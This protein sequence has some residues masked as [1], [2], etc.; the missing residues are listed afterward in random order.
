MNIGK[1][2]KMATTSNNSVADM[3]T[4]SEI[5]EDGINYNL[6][7][8]YS[9]DI[10]YTYSGTILIA[11]NPYKCINIFNKDYVQQYHMA[12]MGSLDP[13]VFAL[14]E[15]AYRSIVEEKINQSCLISGES[16]AGKTESTKFVLQYLCAITSNVS[17]WIQQQILEANT[18][19]EAFGNAKTIRNDN[20]SRFGKFM[21]VCFNEKHTIE[22]CVIQDYLLEQSRI[23]FQGPG[24][25]NYHVMYQLVAQGQTNKEMREN[26]CLRPPEFYRYLN[27]IEDISVDINLES[28]KFNELTMALTVLQIP[29]S[30]IDCIFKVLSSILWLG[31]IEFMDID[32]ERCEFSKTDEEIIVILSKMM[33]LSTNE[34]QMVLL[35]RQINVRGNITE[36]P[37]KLHEARE[38]R[39]AMARALYSKTFTWLVNKINI[40]TSPGKDFNQFLG[41]L[42][43][44]GFENFTRNSFEQLCINYTNEKLHKFFNHYV[45]ALEL[46]IYKQEDINYTHV[47]FTDNSL[48]LELIEKPPRCIFKLLTEQCHMPKGSDSAYLNNLHAEF[49]YNPMYIKGLDRRHWE[50]EFGIRHYAGKVIYSVEG[51][52][53]KN[54]DMQ[55]DVLFDY[56]S[57]SE[58]TFLCDLAKSQDQSC[59]NLIPNVSTNQRG[60][61]KSKST[62]SDQF[63]QQLQSL[64]DVLQNTKLWYIRCIKPNSLKQANIYNESLV[65]DQLRYLGI[66]DIIRIRREGFPIHL[67]FS[68]FISK[69]K[70]VIRNKTFSNS[71]NDILLVLKELKVPETEWQIGK[72]K[73]FLRSSAIEP[74]EDERKRIR[75]ANSIIIQKNWRRYLNNKYYMHVKKSILIIQHAYR[76]WKLR[77]KFLRIRRSVIIIQSRL[78]GV[79]AREVATALRE[80]RRVDEEMK[81]RERITFETPTNDYKAIEDCER[82]VQTEM[83]VLTNMA[84]HMNNSIGKSIDKNTVSEN[85]STE[86]GSAQNIDTV[87]LDNLFAFLTDGTTVPTNSVIEEIND[88]M[89]SLVQDL[90][91]EIETCMQKEPLNYL[92]DQKKNILPTS[93]LPE[94]LMAPPPPP[95][96]SIET[97]S[98]NLKPEPIYE[99]L[100]HS[101]ESKHTSDINIALPL[102]TREKENGIKLTVSPTLVE[103]EREQRRKFRVEKKLL[104]M[105][106]NEIQ[107]EVYNNDS[108]YNILNF[109]E[110]FFN[111]HERFVDGTLISTI[112]R[113]GKKAMDLVPKHEMITFTRSE[114]IATSHIHMYDPENISLSCN[115]FRELSKYMRG[116]Q[117]AERELQ[118]IQYIIGLGIEREELRDEIFVQC[119][120]QTTN[121]P[122]LEWTDRLWLLMCLTI[123]AFQPSK[124]LFRYYFSFLKEKLEV[125]D[126]KLRQYA[127]W[128]F[129]NCKCTKVSTRLQPPS[130]VEVAAMRRLGTIVC[131]F[132]FLDSRTKAIDVHPTDTAIDAVQ[133][134]ADKLNLA[135]I[136]GWAIFQ[137]RPDGEE[138]IKSFEYLYDIISE[139]ESKQNSPNSYKRLSNASTYGENRFVFK[140]R[141]FKPTRELSQD[142]VE[143]GMLY[144]QAVYSIVKCDEFPVSEKVAL[145]LA[146]LQAQVALGDPS[147]QPKPEY[148]CDINSFLPNRIS[149]TREQQFWIP[150]LAQAHRQYGSSR[151]E[152]T[153]KVLYLSCVMQYPLYGTTMFNVIYKG[154]WSFVNNIILGINCEGVLFIQPEDKV[155]IYQFKY[156][157]IESILIDPS[158]SFLTISL[159]RTTNQ[160]PRLTKDDSIFLD[161]Q[162]CFVFETVQKHEIGALIISYYPSLS[163]WI[164]SNFDC[165]KKGKG[166]T[167]EDRTRLYQ[168]VIICRRQLIDLNIVRKPHESGGFLRNTLRRLSKH[169]IE[170]LRAEQRTSPQDHGETYKGF[171]HS[172]WAFSK[173]Q[174]TFCLS[175]LTDQDETTMVQ[176]F[177]SILQFSGLGISGDT[178]KRAEDEHTRIVQ[179]IMDKCM[180]KDSLLNELYLQLI[181]QTTDHP[182]ANSRVNLR[183]W[184]LLSVACSVILPSTKVIRKYLMAHLK[185]CS[186]DFI[187]EEGKYAR[188]AE[189]CFL[190]TQG[191]RRRQWTPSCEEILCTTNR[192]PCYS[193]VFFMDGQY[194]SFEF[195]PSSTAGDVIQ[196]IKKTIGL[197]ENS[198]G[199]ALYEMLGNTER[200]LSNEEKVCD[201]MAKWERYRSVSK[202]DYHP[203][204]NSSMQPQ[205]HQAFLFKKHLF[206][207]A[208]INLD[209]AIEKELLYHQILHSLRSERYPITEMEAIMLTALQ[210]QLELGDYSDNVND[211]GSVASHCLPPRFVPNIPHGAVAMHHQS[212]KG[213]LPVEAKK[214][215]LNLIQ[216]WPLHRATIFD[217]M[218]SFTSNWPRMLW[219]AVDQNGIHLLEHRSRN[220]LCS[221]EY[222]SLIS[223]SPNMNS[224]M[225][226]TGTEK[227]QSKVI[228]STSQA[229]QIAT[230]INEYSE[231]VKRR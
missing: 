213:M 131:R 150:I 223:F 194:Y 192:R 141:L 76:G 110:H 98:R 58:H 77:I 189:K 99:A 174:L 166:I 214:A 188:F 113:K 191:T 227:K 118:S 181:K 144:A 146:G 149:K 4:I 198:L 3:T 210:A 14:A 89:S 201:V 107:N 216:S 1:K 127:Q 13:H 63:R 74:L 176:I 168:N 47:E 137:S 199:Y 75:C 222:E 42:D 171:S 155:I 226:F 50:T 87:D 211:Y 52:V 203:S 202:K 48:C 35:L 21:Q 45:F 68:E 221:H 11:V 122:N 158:D 129:D 34:L 172:F 163:N 80:M 29:Q 228:L 197:Q 83:K 62:V 105:H 138:H 212:L 160:S 200:S 85:N 115:I 6:R 7:L 106:Q 103:N 116:E 24:E 217:V 49:E 104:E 173:Q 130:S 215:F 193:K 55:Q 53:D 139:W 195:H 112:T 134:L 95:I 175:S 185:R 119:M 230:L 167:N 73:I 170:K 10:I 135:S 183:N 23:T 128:C 91:G 140:K 33:G 218:Q 27:T 157:D 180:R 102:S 156:T 111:A 5:D 22:G 32:G 20:S 162:K 51:F 117:N 109:A 120:R 46:S 164:L 8:R 94:P 229:F 147:N 69:Y 114:K 31:N 56:M 161:L 9:N 142:P 100:T 28:R 78:R 41:V 43:I 82:L 182:D 84:E 177:D 71:L 15:A 12:K 225:I 209:D 153:A 190:R 57:R 90:D 178:I 159:N 79:F 86:D 2:E 70:C 60:T 30:D 207:D 38:N 133:K 208:Y 64:I 124:L 186:S 179:S 151:N 132:F 184:A 108:R 18:I 16:G 148:Y 59:S 154:Y 136:E 40:C 66:L 169:R 92:D 219:L 61:S 26:F 205:Q 206:C 81:K 88:T 97:R 25:R 165:T 37:L 39:H 44:F 152:L 93:S 123:V 19:L 231:I 54:R 36:I 121:N 67:T 126:G 143:V 187:S 72:T 101:N 17:S 224:L 204:I 96:N 220:I 65:L 125:L 196:I 145:Q